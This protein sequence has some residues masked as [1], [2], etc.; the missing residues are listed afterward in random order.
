MSGSPKP[1]SVREKTGTAA[2]T[3]VL[4]GLGSGRM[5]GW[6]EENMFVSFCLHC[7]TALRDATGR[8][9]DRLTQIKAALLC[10]RACSVHIRMCVVCACVRTVGTCICMYIYVCVDVHVRKVKRQRETYTFC[11]FLNVWKEVY[12]YV[13]T[14]LL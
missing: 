1:L 12:V 6:G 7:A 4:S 2:C 14:R 10:V 9:D 13:R 8:L 3:C 11:V 5:D